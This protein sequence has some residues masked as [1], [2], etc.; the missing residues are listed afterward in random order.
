M[1]PPSVCDVGIENV[2]RN[3]IIEGLIEIIID[4]KLQIFE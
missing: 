3:L 1:E 4:K 2:V